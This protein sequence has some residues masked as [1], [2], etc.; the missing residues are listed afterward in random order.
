VSEGR[1]VVL[2]RGTEERER[3]GHMEILL[4]L[5]EFFRTFPIGG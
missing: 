1:R 4:A 5:I 3:G 2:P